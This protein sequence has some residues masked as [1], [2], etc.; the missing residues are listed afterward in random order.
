MWN[1]KL[2]SGTKRLFYGMKRLWIGTKWR[3]TKR[4]DTFLITPYHLLVNWKKF[5]D[6][7]EQMFHNIILSTSLYQIYQICDWMFENKTYKQVSSCSSCTDS[8]SI[9]FLRITC[10]FLETTHPNSLKKKNNAFSIRC[11]TCRDL[12][13]FHGIVSLDTR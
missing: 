1:K 11:W 6:T 9:V 2:F 8:L 4:P 3:R 13:V 12:I 7:T 5:V 10:W